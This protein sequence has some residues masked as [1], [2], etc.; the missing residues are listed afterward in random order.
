MAKRSFMKSKVQSK[1]S[2]F[3]IVAGIILVCLILAITGLRVPVP[4]QTETLQLYNISEIRFGIDIVGGV[5]AVFAAKD[6]DGT[7]T[8]ADL[9]AARSIIELRMDNLAILD[10]EITVDETHGRIIVRYPWKSGETDFDP[11][12]ALRE[13]GEM[14]LL[15]FT[16]PD[17]TVVL[18]GA[19]VARSVAGFDPTNN[20]PIVQLELKPDGA[21]KFAEATARLIG[22]PITISMDEIEISAPVVRT[23]I[24]GGNAVISNIGSIQ[25]AVA[26]AEKINAG[27][28]PFALEAISSRSISPTLGQNA[29]NVMTQAGLVAF[30]LICLFM[31]VRY[32]LPGIIAS[33]ALLGQITGILLAITIPQQTLTLQGI[34]G[35]ILSIGMGVDASIIIAERIKEELRNGSG[36]QLALTNGFARALSAVIDGNVTLAISAAILMIFGSGSMLSFGY[37]LLSGVIFNGLTA[38]IAS[39]FMLGSL[40]QFKP[41]KNTWLYGAG[42]VKANV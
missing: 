3:F 42:R 37:S 39:R 15:S 40:S 28:L 32:R 38:V 24:D 9:A 25:E 30:L 12:K 29:L 14:A 17:G 18:T 22:Q 11:A 13:L 5:D 21:V 36:L 1:P 16:E 33:I 2:T 35:I 27:A 31:I 34:A 20:E 41:L 7:P 8:A 10:R 26:L 23:A 6:Y 19:D 4:G